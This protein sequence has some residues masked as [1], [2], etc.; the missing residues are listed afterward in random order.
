MD[1]GS[2]YVGGFCS[3]V[4]PE[5]TK[6]VKEWCVRCLKKSGEGVAVVR[7]AQ[8]Q[9]LKAWKEVQE[10][11]DLSALREDGMRNLKTRCCSRE[12]RHV[13]GKLRVV[14]VDVIP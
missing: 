6:L 8:F 7:R 5:F 3:R 12:K 1:S 4:L 9:D 13:R 14:A 2:G 10:E 11:D